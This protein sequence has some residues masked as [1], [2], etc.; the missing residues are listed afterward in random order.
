MLG[1]Y[2][3]TGRGACGPQFFRPF[4]CR[5]GVAETGVRVINLETVVLP[6]L[7]S[8]DDA[9]KVGIRTSGDMSSYWYQ[10]VRVWYEN[11]TPSA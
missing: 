1:L 3:R 7:S 10:I 4:V 9:S 2:H 8:V 11:P 6:N 5:T